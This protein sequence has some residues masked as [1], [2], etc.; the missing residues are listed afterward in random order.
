MPKFEVD[1]EKLQIATGLFDYS[2]KQMEEAMY[3]FKSLNG[4]FQADMQLQTSIE[5]PKIQEVCEQLSGSLFVLN[6]KM[7]SLYSVLLQIPGMY[8]HIEENSKSRLEGVVVKTDCTQR[9]IGDAAAIDIAVTAETDEDVK[10]FTDTANLVQ[11]NSFNMSLASTASAK[12]FIEKTYAK[13]ADT[14]AG[15]VVEK[16]VKASLGSLETAAEE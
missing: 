11:S 15:N 16:Q 12:G 8:S 2:K 4:E 7:Q 13:D 6:D 9:N 14:D 1:T 5:Y 10:S 3:K